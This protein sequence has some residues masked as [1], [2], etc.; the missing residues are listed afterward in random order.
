[1]VRFCL[2]ARYSYPTPAPFLSS[3]PH[4]HS[5][6]LFSSVLHSIEEQKKDRE[7]IT[8]VVW[9]LLGFIEVDLVFIC[10]QVHDI[11]SPPLSSSLFLCI[12]HSMCTTHHAIPRHTMHRQVTFLLSGVNT[13]KARLTDRLLH[14][15]T[16]YTG[17]ISL[18]VSV[19][20]LCVYWVLMLK[21]ALG[22]IT[23]HFL[24]SNEN[25]EK[26]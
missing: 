25:R 8:F 6:R 10:A 22:I 7:K 1:M 19:H 12:E 16:E 14:L 21:Y 5:F 23:L 2:F 20:S 15:L 13:T 9:L 3:L 26:N 18:S 4:F 17:S 11:L 24:N